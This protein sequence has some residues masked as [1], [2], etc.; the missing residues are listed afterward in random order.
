MVVWP[1]PLVWLCQ[2]DDLYTCIF[3]EGLHACSQID[4]L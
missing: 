4:M 2:G 1:V 3:A